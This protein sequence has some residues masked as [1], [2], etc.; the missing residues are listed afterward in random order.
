MPTNHAAPHDAGADEGMHDC[1]RGAH[2]AAR[3]TTAHNG[4]RVTTPAQTYRAFCEAC[5]DH[6]HACLKDLPTQYRDLAA[7]IGVKTRADRPRVSGGGKTSHI[8]L[9]LGVEALMRQIVEIILSWDERVRPPARLSELAAPN[10]ADALTPACEMLA[11][12][13]GVLLGLPDEDMARTMD[14]ARAE[15]LPQDA[16]GWVHLSGEWILYNT[17]LSGKDAGIEILNLHHRC[18]KV[19]GRTPQHQDLVTP[20]WECGERTTLRRHDGTAGLADYVHCSHC[21]EQYLGSRLNALMVEEEEAQRRRHDRQWRRAEGRAAVLHR[22]REGVGG[23][24]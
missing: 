17:A 9:N 3:T 5:S 1:A 22:S 2:C 13:T 23:R 11:A 21:G 20:C 7:H 18:L 8:P 19:L 6:I 4:E 12:H 14:L 10:T 16:T 15:H 24:A